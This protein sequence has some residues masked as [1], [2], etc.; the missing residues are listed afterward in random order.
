MSHPEAHPLTGKL[1]TIRPIKADN[2]ILDW[3][4]K[5]L[6]GTEFVIEDWY[7]RLNDRPWQE[8]TD[9]TSI[10]YITR[11]VWN[12]LPRDNEVVV[13]LVGRDRFLVHAAELE[14]SGDLGDLDV[15]A[16]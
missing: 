15:P 7:D 10:Y 11:M 16:V 12:G 5:V 1:V 14:F 13:G 9:P 3:A 4:T 2:T 6:D 8:S